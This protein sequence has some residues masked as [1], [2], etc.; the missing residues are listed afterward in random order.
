[1]ASEAATALPTTPNPVMT[2]PPGED[3]A[4]EAGERE[5]IDTDDED[6]RYRLTVNPSKP[7]KI[8]EKKLR[9]HAV[10]QAWIA[11][12]QRE[13]AKSA[14]VTFND[15]EKQSLTQL[16]HMSENRKIISTPR[17]YQ[18]D[19]FE[20]AKEKNT[21]VVLP[22]G[23]GK[24][25]I[26]ALLLRHHLEREVEVRATGGTKKVAFFLVE[27]VALCVQQYAVL[28]CNLGEHPVVK[29]TGNTTGLMKNKAYWDNQFNENMVVVCTAQILLDC[30]YSGF[31]TMSQINLL[32]FDE[33][34]HAKREHPY[35]RIMKHHYFAHQ[36]HRPRILGMTASPVDAKTRDVK[37]TALELE[38]ALNSQ[39]ATV[40]DEVLIESMA[41]Q[42]QVEERVDYTPLE[43][44]EDTK[45][46]LWDSIFAQVSRNEQFKTSLEFTKEASSSL[47]PWCADR[48]WQLLITDTETA[49]LA[50][51]TDREYSG[52][53]AS[54]KADQATEAVRRV[55]TITKTHQFGTIDPLSQEL[56]SKV[57]SLHE[58][59]R[60]AFT[61]DG[62]KRCIVF[63][64]KRY[65]ACLLS[66]LYGQGSMRIPGMTA[67]YMVGCQ[68]TTAQLGN[69]S[70][71]DQVLTLQKFKRGDINC[72][73]ATPVAEEGIDVP[74]CDLVIRF[75]LYNSVIQYL[76]SK[77]RARQA[78]SRYITM[79]EDGNLR[80]LRSL[81][82]AERDATA[83]QKFCMSLPADRKLQDDSIDATA[84]IREELLRQ[85]V[86]E[87][88]STGAR[89]TFPSSLEV[90]ARFA[91]ASSSP[92]EHGKV[93]YQTHK[94]TRTQFVSDV[95]LPISCP[96][97][98]VSG[99]PQRSRMLAKCSAAFEACK[100][101]IKNKYVDEHLQPTFHKKVHALRNAR[102]S[103][104]SNKKAEY[105]MRL[106]P[107]VWEAR[108]EWTVCFA[109]TITLD[110]AGALGDGRPGRSLILLSRKLL[111]KL[112]EIPLF[113]G[114]G[115][116]SVVQLTPSREPLR[117]TATETDGLTQ[118]TFR[119]FTDVFSKEY[120]ATCDEFPYLLAP[121]A[122][123]PTPAE[124]QSHIDW[125]TVNL[126]KYNETLDWENA[127][128]E[129]FMNKLVTDPYDGGR[130]LIIKGIDDSKRPSDP[131]PEGVP[132]SRSRA[133]RVVEQTIKEYSNSLYQKSRQK[134][135]WREDQPV[136]KAELL[137]L[138]RNL[139]DEF[140]VDEEVNKD[141]FVILEPLK[142]S[143]LP[144]DVV[145]IALTFPAI[146]HRIDSALI[147]LDMCDL[148]GLAIP[149]TL[150]LEAM[151]KDSDNSEEHDKE[152]INFQPG[153][154]DNYER[155][156][157]LGDCFLKM[158]TTISIFT[159]MPDGDECKY[160]VERMILICNQNLFN[161]AVDR[162]LQEYIRSKSFDRRT[163]YPDLLLKKG[164]A[165][166]P[167]M[168]HN[169]ADKTIADVCEA[170]IG[171][172]Y[173]SSKDDNMDMAVKAVTRMVKSKNHKMEVFDDYFSSFKVPAW[174][175]VEGNTGQR[176]LV[177][178]VADATGYHFKSPPLVQS[179]FKHPSWPYEAVPNYQRLEFLGDALLDM[180][181]VDY[182]YRQFP[183]AD[184]Q[185]L[186]E[187]K[188]AMVSNQFLGCLCVKLGLHKH[189]LFTT[190]A[191]IGQIHNYVTELEIAE[192]DARKEAEAEGVPMRKNFWLKASAPPKAYAD[193]MEALLGAIFVDSEYNYLVVENFFTKFVKP[194]FEDMTLYDT[195][196]NNHPVTFL[197]KKM[198]Q[199]LGCANWRI[200]AEAVPCGAEEGM[201]ALKESDVVA[202]FMV[203]QQVIEN[204]T[205]KSG[206]YAK[207]AVAKR[208]L[209]MIKTFGDDFA[210]AKKALG[211]D[212]KLGAGEDGQIDHGTA[213]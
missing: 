67:S 192:E 73:F 113:F 93:D 203:H 37:A 58:I 132:E 137:S 55:Q 77:G 161:H 42:K 133:Y 167:T 115:R 9:D 2:M 117:L 185:W 177:K 126:V 180:A 212:C 163:W 109:M 20:R 201:A 114:N 108:G 186:T 64:E 147:A 47:G 187:H 38:R 168:R 173:L 111:P 100:I 86:H 43:F 204:S 76:Q 198:Q 75:D 7:R 102:L 208:A 156:E 106:R 181:I 36:G 62:T 29:F 169:L 142:V 107:D 65:T 22:T 188:M 89:L 166:K 4:N 61:V 72:L 15:P 74:D 151:T 101:L 35:A 124:T 71:R 60:H 129:F 130:K 128:K 53:F 136:V 23:S 41:R 33:A 164:K 197:S 6:D 54:T 18:I 182:L 51:R 105:N 10:L 31:I 14:L 211:C 153:M 179:A 44:P 171:A 49:R 210:A 63:A 123:N 138:R 125:D 34:H 149:P 80:Q 95:V 3:Q 99:F 170:L 141:C 19:L 200:S 46:Q 144:I 112:P 26:S 83:L 11:K 13:A 118:F 116:S 183:H 134:A 57:K 85:K 158:A 209:E 30:L 103:V 135:Q 110:N 162:Q 213:V 56:S 122:D 139:L 17:E 174:Q 140:Q 32:I 96:V 90:L 91:Y 120:N 81:K 194:Y 196:A 199:D 50:A 59:L 154:G 39:I 24:T 143:P 202:V 70:F 104:S 52:D 159:L 12:N 146:I 88:P 27:K 152:Q 121:F 190:S 82:Q 131:T 184:P 1:M 16:I 69:M 66:D 206:R 98:S 25:L 78:S 189:L 5:Y 127:P 150:A 87:I 175:K 172:A 148:L 79:L 45:T 207:V 48:Y 84:E 97:N 193:S 160:H 176:N 8:T 195:F 40:S 178:K 94:I 92:E 165:S 145:Y 205:S 157:F 191:M 155:L 28:D 21:I 68:S 119:V